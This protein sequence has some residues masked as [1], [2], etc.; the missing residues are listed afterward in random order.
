MSDH[1]STTLRRAPSWAASLPEE[2]QTPCFVI[3]ERGIVDNLYATARVCG[4]V[5]RL[6]PHVKTHR[7]GWVVKRL[8]R[9][10]VTAFKAATVAEVAMVLEAGAKHVVW[11][12]PTVNRAHI[13]TLLALAHARPD[14]RVDALV[15][16]A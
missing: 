7:A 3:S 4:G 2:L 6:M 14:A 13:R 5:E 15:D 11:A 9:E 12:Y 16:S 1:S 10:G 8:I